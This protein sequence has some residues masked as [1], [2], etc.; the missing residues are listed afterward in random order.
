V[1]PPGSAPRWRD[2]RVLDRAAAVGLLVLGLLEAAFGAPAGPSRWA[3][4]GLTVLWSLPLAVRRRYPVPVLALVVV[5]GPTYTLV[6]PDGGVVSY[7]VAVLLASYTVGRH[8]DPPATW[9]GPAL[10]IGF[11][12]LLSAVTRNTE[13]TSYAYAVILYGAAWAVGY[14]IRRR[15]VE[16][17][18]EAEALRRHRAEFERRAVTEERSR[19]ARELHDIVS[20]SLSVITIQTQA[21]RRRLG[22]RTGTEHGREIEDLRAV[23]A[24]SRQAMAEMRR[25][26]GVLRA[27]GDPP[28]LTP[29]PG[30]DQLPR[31][32]AETR[33]AGLPVDLRVDGE[34]GERPPGVDLTAYRVVQEALTNVRKHTRDGTA[35]VSVSHTPGGLTL[36]IADDGTPLGEPAT[37]DGHGLVGMRERVSLY[38]GTLHAGRAPD[39]RFVVR[40]DLPT[41]RPGTAS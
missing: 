18:A 37:D 25:L 6:N 39:G 8:L 38:G 14:A 28:D 34:P 30:L 21:V 12:W 27:D 20:H 23:E 24:T 5:L 26:L 35:T 4:A 19:I 36:E 9:W 16:L 22:D 10:S 3:Q 13:L 32:V 33:R 2:E 17:A 7:V 11:F 31:L 29:Q 15:E 40:A 1:R 41:G